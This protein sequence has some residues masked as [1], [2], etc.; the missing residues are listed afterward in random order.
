MDLT[1][2]DDLKFALQ[3]AG[4]KSNKGLGQHF[5]VDQD[6]LEL[7]MAAGELSSG[8]I[9]VEVGPGLGVMTMPLTRQ[10]KQVIAI[11]MDTHLADLLE[12]RKPDNLEIRQHDV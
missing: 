3:L 10:V 6:S 12:R 7:V 5:L 11:E 8:D 2:V 1:N 4:L 9:V